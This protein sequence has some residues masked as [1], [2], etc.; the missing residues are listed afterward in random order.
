[1]LIAQARAAGVSPRQIRT[2]KSNGWQTSVRGVLIDPEAPDPF[3]ASVRAALLACDKAVAAGFTA[4]RLHRLWGLP[5]WTP[6]ESPEL[7]LPSGTTF[8]RRAG[9]FL[10]S[11]LQPGERT[12]RSGFAVT[13]LGRT[14]LDVVPRLGFEDAV[15]LVDRALD[16]GWQPQPS[17]WTR[18]TGRL[19]R[20]LLAVADRRSES[21]LETRVRLIFV[22]AGVPPEALQYEVLDSTGWLIARL[23]MAWPS[24]RLAVEV[25]GRAYHDSVPAVYRDRA[26]ANKLATRGWRI[27]RFT[28]ADLQ[29]SEW[30][31]AQVRAALA[32]R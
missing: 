20:P 6:Q 5:V 4:A 11:G 32:G 9:V 22:A 1:V 29:H 18:R 2:L 16:R 28:W 21:P 12:T 17:T 27:L 15:A 25:D 26:R 31:V 24:A 10:R 7:L 14:V 30:I 13:T 8:E 19:L 3:R 23:D